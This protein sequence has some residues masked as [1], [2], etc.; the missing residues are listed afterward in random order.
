MK[1]EKYGEYIFFCFWSL[2]K[3]E[4]FKEENDEFN[5][6]FSMFKMVI[7]LKY[8]ILF[9]KYGDCFFFCSGK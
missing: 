7:M 9:C 2:M 4:C 3:R 6:V 1:V 5:V 8:C